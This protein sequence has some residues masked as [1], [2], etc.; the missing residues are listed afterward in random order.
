MNALSVSL[1]TVTRSTRSPCSSKSSLNIDTDRSSATAMSMPLALRGALP[2]AHWGRAMPTMRSANPNQR[3]ARSNR[4]A[5][6][7]FI[8]RMP[9][10]S[11]R[12]E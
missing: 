7:R 3:A 5:R 1:A 12:L 11:V 4:L 8:W 9:F 2:T 6:V 10:T